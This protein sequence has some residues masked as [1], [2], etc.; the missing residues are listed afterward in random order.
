MPRKRKT[1]D[2]DGLYRR[3]D[4][5]YWWA[6]YVDASGSRVRRSTG[7]SER[8]EAE[9]LL[10]KWRVET[11]RVRHW[12]EV[13]TR[14]FEELMVAYLSATTRQKRSAETDRF[15]A[16]A[17][18]GYFAGVELNTLDPTHIRGYVAWRRAQRVTDTTINRDLALLSAAIGYA[19]T[20]WDWRLPNPTRGR[21]LTEPEGR[22]RWIT[23]EEAARLVE[24]AEKARRVP[25]L[26]DL[27]TVALFTGCR[28]EELLGLEWKRVDLDQDLLHLEAHHTKSGRRRSVPLCEAARGALLRRVAFR[29]ATSPNSPWVFA[30]ADGTRMS[31][32]RGAFYK[33]CGEA[34]IKDFRIH[35]LRH[36]CAAWLVSAGAPLAEIR[37]LLGHSTILM[38]E[39]YAHLAPEN[40]RATVARFDA[41]R[42]S[43][44]ESRGQEPTPGC[45]GL[46][47]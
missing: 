8:K 43:H 13:P 45:M 24:A 17:L 23:R 15:R 6:S 46:S 2:Q 16:K 42:F 29:A 5:P 4:S 9:T 35:D 27:I 34:G 40:L 32:V 10:A 3:T 33:A 28:K 30:K 36:T 19:N 7:T 41:S 44:V 18:R 25:F 22:V 37:D 20:E 47:S 11:H 31:N 21:K 26:A 38:T 1:L 12:D 14:T 39:R